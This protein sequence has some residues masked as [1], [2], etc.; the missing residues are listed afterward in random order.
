MP[1]T[2]KKVNNT[3][4]TARNFSFIAYPENISFDELVKKLKK[5]CEKFVISPLHDADLNGDDSEKKAHWHIYLYFEGKKSLKQVNEFAK[6]CNGAFAIIVTNRVG[7]MRY[8]CHLDNPEKAQYDKKDVYACGIDYERTIMSKDDY[9]DLATSQVE[10]IIDEQCF[11][12][13][14]KLQRYLKENHY[15]LWQYVRKHTYYINN[16]IKSGAY[17]LS[18][19]SK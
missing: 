17:D 12:S 11:T 6:E 5:F 18:L 3:P 10:N 9:D 13:L 19:S 15:S 2:S 16:Y 8:L 14:A 1:K 4:K 7:L